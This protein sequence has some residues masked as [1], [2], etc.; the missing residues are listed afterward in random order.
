[1]WLKALIVFGAEERSLTADTGIFS[2]NFWARSNFLLYD[3]ALYYSAIP[4]TPY[5]WLR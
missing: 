4:L 5:P 3:I 2:L 1:M